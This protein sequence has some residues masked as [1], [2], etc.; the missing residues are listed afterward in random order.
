MQFGGRYRFATAR[1]A[2]WAAL[3]DTAVLQAV[4]PGCERIAWTAPHSLDLAI[5]VNLG[6]LHPVFRGE[7]TL[8]DVD[9]AVRYT[10][11]GR[12][13][14]GVLGLAQGAAD[15]RLAD[16]GDATLLTFVAHG[17]AD[18]GIMKLGRALLGRSAQHVI[19]GFFG[20]LGE[21]LGVGVTALP[22]PEF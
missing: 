9:P 20:A 5:R 22:P 18:T 12:G 13:R 3:N 6:L 2:L 21:T 4:I 19:D 16:D 1:P 10:L 7:L 11:S 14:G 8:S 17:K 15:I